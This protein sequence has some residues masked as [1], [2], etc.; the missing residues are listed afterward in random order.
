MSMTDWAKRE[1]EIACKREA[2]DR[3][4]DEWD[5]GCACYES[6][7]KA[8][9]SMMEDEHSGMSFSFTAGILKRLLEAKPL[10]PIEDV[11]EMWNECWHLD[12][13]TVNYQCKRMSSL[14][15]YVS[16][17]GSVK[18]SDVR[19]YYCEDVETGVTYSCGLEANMLDELHPIT[20]PYYP[21]LGYYVF[22]SKELLTDRKNGD[23]DTK[24]IIC[25]KH[26][27]GTVEGIGRYFAVGKEG[28]HEISYTKFL[29]R[30]EADRRRR[31]Q[32]KNGQD[33]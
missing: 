24:A 7:L 3:K 13:G 23:F 33:D 25:L 20:M 6:A 4:E 5:Y 8:Y 21:P 17:D 22:R 18:Y 27:D 11:P 29:R 14:F 19:R 10:T 31:E 1:V 16:P 9:L 2:P 26:P 30:R 28:W 32:E 12:D 15:K